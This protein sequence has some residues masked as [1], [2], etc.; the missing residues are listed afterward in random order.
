M[1][2]VVKGESVQW[3]NSSRSFDTRPMRVF[4]IKSIYSFIIC[5]SATMCSGAVFATGGQII[6][7]HSCLLEALLPSGP[8]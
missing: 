7:C 1:T 8:S 3:T 6:S 2:G 5:I 4:I